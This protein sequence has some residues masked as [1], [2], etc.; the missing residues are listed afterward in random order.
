V[1]AEVV[2]RATSPDVRIASN[3]SEIAR[4]N[5][6]DYLEVVASHGSGS[7]QTVVALGEVSPEFQLAFL[8]PA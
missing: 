7:P 8:R 2:R 1:V 3:A 4:L 5:A 6:G